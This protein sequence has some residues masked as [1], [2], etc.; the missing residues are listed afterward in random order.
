MSGAGSGRPM[1]SDSPAPPPE[2]PAAIVRPY[3]GED[4]EALLAIGA[5]TAFFGAPVEAFHED[6]RLFCDLLYRYYVDHEPDLARVAEGAG[7][8]AGFVVGAEDT[9]AMRARWWRSVV[10]GVAGRLVTGRYRLGRKTLRFFLRQ[11]LGALRGENPHVDRDR[12]PAHLH[13][14]VAAGWRSGG[15][16]RALLEAFFEGLRRRGVGGVH[17]FTTDLNAAACHLYESMGFALLDERPS[18]QWGGLVAG[19]VRN[20][21]YGLRL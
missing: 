21:A 7:E 4:R 19:P 9:G 8:I 18:R 12:Y 20:R 2:H 17:L 11:G 5:D 1:A 15:I 13:V 16:G 6:R 10:P 3:R 14:N